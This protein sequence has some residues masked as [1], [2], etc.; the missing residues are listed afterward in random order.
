MHLM[1][2]F[3]S[4]V[5]QAILTYIV[6][7]EHCR[8][9]HICLS[10]TFPGFTVKKKKTV[11]KA[12]YTDLASIMSRRRNLEGIES[13]LRRFN[14]SLINPSAGLFL[15]VTFSSIPNACCYDWRN[16][17]IICDVFGKKKSSSCTNLVWCNQLVKNGF[18]TQ[19]LRLSTTTDNTFHK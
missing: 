16:P 15:S 4:F 6:K 12:K 18:M 2:L 10:Q 8:K 13:S 11:Q 3:F 9:Q 19:S 5:D 1:Y 14:P 7:A 17:L